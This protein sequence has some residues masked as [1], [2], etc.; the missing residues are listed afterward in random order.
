[1]VEEATIELFDAA[2][3]TLPEQT[4]A[5]GALT[6][7]TD[8]QAHDQAAPAG[9]IPIASPMPYMATTEE[10]DVVGEVGDILGNLLQLPSTTSGEMADEDAEQE[11]AADGAGGATMAEPL[12]PTPA[13]ILSSAAPE[14]VSPMLATAEPEAELTQITQQRVSPSP[15]ATVSPTQTLTPSPTASPTISATIVSTPVPT[16]VS[17]VSPPS[18]LIGLV[19]VGLGLSLGIVT[20]VI[21]RRAVNL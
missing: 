1:V 10:S 12:S 8:D 2:A 7:E 16:D 9:T 14:I 17:A 4:D 6:Y 19:L 5:V 13:A 3:E 18:Q 11:E 15:T 21:A 20:L